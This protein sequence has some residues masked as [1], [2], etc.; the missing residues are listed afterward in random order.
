[1]TGAISG[2]AHAA[3]PNRLREGL[4]SYTSG[5]SLNPIITFDVVRW[6]GRHEVRTIS[7]P[8][9]ALAVR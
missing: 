2:V 5:A 1:M 6:R 3:Q 7:E 9:T 4:Y 8:G